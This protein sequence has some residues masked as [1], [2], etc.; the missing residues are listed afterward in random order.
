MLEQ[1]GGCGRFY[2]VATTLPRHF[3]A[4]VELMY[5]LEVVRVVDGIQIEV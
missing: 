4:C 1:D 3:A 2:L 5:S